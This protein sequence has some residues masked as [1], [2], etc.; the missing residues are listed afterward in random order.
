MIEVVVTR[1]PTT[2]FITTLYLHVNTSED[3]ACM[4]GT[5]L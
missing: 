1:R 4:I 2:E 3:F 5:E